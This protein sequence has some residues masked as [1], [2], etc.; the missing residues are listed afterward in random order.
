MSQGKV[1]IPVDI[2]RTDDV[3]IKGE[4]N[5]AVADGTDVGVVRVHGLT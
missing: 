1:E 3:G 2:L 4:L 5:T